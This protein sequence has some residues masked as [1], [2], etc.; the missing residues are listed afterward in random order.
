MPMWHGSNLLAR[1]Y[2]QQVCQKLQPAD[3]SI[4]RISKVPNV[5]A[6]L[7][8]FGRNIPL[9]RVKEPESTAGFSVGCYGWYQHA[10]WRTQIS[11]ITGIIGPARLLRDFVQRVNAIDV[12]AVKTPDLKERYAATILTAEQYAVRVR[13]EIAKWRKLITD[14]G[15]KVDPL[16]GKREPA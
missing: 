1:S 13:E 12:Q 11:T 9:A 14:A 2:T 10:H 5:T 15:I 4:C 8:S 7:R 16:R 3:F 6:L